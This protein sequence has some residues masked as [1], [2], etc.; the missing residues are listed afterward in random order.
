MVGLAGLAGLAELAGL[1]GLGECW[2]RAARSYGTDPHPGCTEWVL[3]G[4]IW[5]AQTSH[6]GGLA[7]PF[8]HPGGPCGR[9]GGPRGHPRG[10]LGVHVDFQRFLMDFGSPLGA[11]WGSFGRLFRDLGQR[12][13]SLGSGVG[14]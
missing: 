14:F 13:A 4:V 11:T 7:A 12:N 3:D 1:A 8:G 5:G 2:A 6:L 10:H 9:S